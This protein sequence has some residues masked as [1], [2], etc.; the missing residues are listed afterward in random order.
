[1]SV[2]S[3]IKSLNIYFF[4]CCFAFVFVRPL[5][6]GWGA[7]ADPA[8]SAAQRDEPRQGGSYTEGCRGVACGAA[9]GD[10]R[11]RCSRRW[12]VSCLL[13]CGALTCRCRILPVV[14]YRIHHLTASTA[15]KGG[16]DSCV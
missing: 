2:C 3:C 4:I 10:V 13:A 11:L 7:G 15:Q 1:M 14:F 5:I 12:V 9:F 6:T 16:A 8:V